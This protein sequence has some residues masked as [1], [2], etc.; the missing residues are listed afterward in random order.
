[1]VVDAVPPLT[2]TGL[3]IGAVPFRNCTVPVAFDGDTAAFNWTE[4]PNAWG[5]AG[6]VVSAV[7]VIVVG[8]T[9]D[10][11]LPVTRMSAES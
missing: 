3:P 11:V 5:L 2:V 6:V 8:K 1:M 4:V 7:V 10:H 9:R